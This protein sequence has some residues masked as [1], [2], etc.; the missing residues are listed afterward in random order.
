MPAAKTTYLGGPGGLMVIDVAGVATYP[1]ADGYG[2]IVGT[3]DA[4]GVF[5]ANPP[6]DELPGADVVA[7]AAQEARRCSQVRSSRLRSRRGAGT[8]G[9]FGHTVHHDEQRLMTL[10]PAGWRRLSTHAAG[11]RRR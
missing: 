11:D 8:G 10:P 6:T 1:L 3:T 2:D 5:V 7:T 4:L 9:N